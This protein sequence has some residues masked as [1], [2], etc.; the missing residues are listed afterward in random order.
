MKYRIFSASAGFL[1]VYY[2]NTPREAVDMFAN[3]AGYDDAED[4]NAR[5]GG[6]WRRDLVV[7]DGKT[8]KEVTP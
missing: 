3:D 1:G 7:Y 6:N 4:M 8:A 5:T 2:G